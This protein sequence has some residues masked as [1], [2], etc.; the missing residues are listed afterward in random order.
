MKLSIIIVNFN[1]GRVTQG[2]LAA[3]LDHRLPEQ[4]EII[5]VDNGSRDDSV[6]FLKSDFPEINVI[7]NKRNLGYAA[8]VNIGL[9]KAKGEFILILNPDII[10]LPDAVVKLVSFMDKNTD[11]GMAGAMLMSPNGQLQTSCFRYYTPL[12]IFYRRTW[13]GKTRLGRR[14]LS[15]FLMNDY[16]HRN[17]RDVE[18][19][20]GS[21]LIVRSRA[22]RQVGGMDERFFMYFEDV[23]WCRRMWEFGWRVTY[24]PQAVFSHFYQQSSR[25]QS[26]F[27][28]ITN[29]STRDHIRS[30]AR[31]F[32]KYKGKPRLHIA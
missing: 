19:L 25:K 4:T 7:D 11:V 16:D 22:A 5:V 27:G 28:I 26:L 1:S 20:M 6:L 32:N 30:A 12:T 29:R 10:A 18:W 3:L 31:Y 9:A 21:C 13:L 2:C 17:V 14:A 24:V 23:D 15:N 8:G